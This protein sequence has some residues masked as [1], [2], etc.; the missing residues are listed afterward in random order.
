MSF[1]YYILQTTSKRTRSVSE[2]RFYDYREAKKAARR[3][4]RMKWVLRVS[5]TRVHEEPDGVWRNGRRS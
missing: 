5:M 1:P 3:V 2:A 4:S